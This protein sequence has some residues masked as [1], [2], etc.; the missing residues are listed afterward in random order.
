MKLSLNLIDTYKRIND[1]YYANR[2]RENENAPQRA[3]TRN[4]P[5][6]QGVHNHGWDDEH[7][8]YIL[9]RG[10]MIQGRYRIQERIGKGS[11]GQVVRAFDTETDKDVAI[12]IIKSRRPFLLQARTEIELLVHLKQRD[13]E[14]QNNIGEFSSAYPS[15]DCYL[16]FTHIF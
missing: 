16:F 14:D 4:E 3:D 1:A 9:I 12:K 15:S 8:D 6:G 13:P 11:F 7:Y 2:R 10:E 5:R